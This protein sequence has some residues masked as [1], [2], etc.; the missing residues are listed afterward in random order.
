MDGPS[1]LMVY[2]HHNRYRKKNGNFPEAVASEAEERT[3]IRPVYIDDN[4]V[5]FLFLVKSP[6]LK[7]KLEHALDR[8]KEKYEGSFG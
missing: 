3:G 1:V 6:G 5:M 4:T 7:E 2:Q 8:Y